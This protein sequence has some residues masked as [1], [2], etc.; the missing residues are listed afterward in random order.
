MKKIIIS[1]SI[2]VSSIIIVL[3]CVFVLKG[4]K[5]EIKVS[6]LDQY[7]TL[8]FGKHK[9]KK[10]SSDKWDGSN[11]QITFQINDE[12][13]FYNNVIKKC[14]YYNEELMHK[15]NDYYEKYYIYG[16]MIK[17][18]RLFNY[19]I[20]NNIV[21]I[22]SMESIYNI[23]NL[24]YYIFAPL[25]PYITNENLLNEDIY[26]WCREIE[27]YYISFDFLKI[28]ISNLDDSIYKI[29]DKEIYLKGYQF[30]YSTNQIT[31]LSEEYLIK[32]CIVDSKIIVD[33]A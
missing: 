16:Y 27:D 10:F 31:T 30:D 15:N 6:S 20:Y 17:D 4:K 8:D 1:L 11:Y 12:V 7:V 26:E 29:D 9:V 23:N 33:V 19:Y 14:E 28:I 22:R 18:N 21:T 3:V 25:F 5:Y 24:N 32:I 13:Y 2:L